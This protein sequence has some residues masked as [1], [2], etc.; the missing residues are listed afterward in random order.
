MRR[1]FVSIFIGTC[2]VA[3]SLAACTL[4]TAA[5]SS[6]TPQFVIPTQFNQPTELPGVVTATPQAALP[7]T[8]R[9]TQAP[10]VPA[11]EPT[12]APEQPIAPVPVVKTPAVSFQGTRIAMQ[13]GS[14]NASVESSVTANGKAN[15]LVGASAGQ[16]LMVALTSA[17]QA[18]SLQILAP[19]GSV[20]G[21][22]ANQ[23][24]LWQGSL[25]SDGDYLISVIS[26]GEAAQFNLNITIPVRVTFPSG[27]IS[28]SQD[29]RVP[30]QG[31]NTYL[32]RAIQDQTLSVAITSAKNDIF[33]TIYGL[34]DGQPYLRSASGSTHASIK[35]PSTQD[36]VI[37]AV[38]S[39]PSAEN[40]TIEFKAQ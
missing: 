31:I 38:S 33:L 23:V 20:L 11:V 18:L 28:T 19:D 37:Q 9:S 7:T 4:P 16:Y 25:P 3:I 39:D 15:F 12:Q 5:L 30:P 6:P 13:P 40:Y 27:A 36:Y 21:T 32:L 10:V 1:T 8:S 22:A 34:E 14:T 29:G 26:T 17:N 35:L 2:F 24:G